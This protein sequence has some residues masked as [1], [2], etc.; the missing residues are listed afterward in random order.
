MYGYGAAP[1]EI[2]RQA[3][4]DNSGR[5]GRSERLGYRLVLPPH[6]TLAQKLEWEGG[7]GA[8]IGP[9]VLKGSR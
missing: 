5:N 6:M 3:P 9:E 7:V 2:R 8:L 1:S 4:G